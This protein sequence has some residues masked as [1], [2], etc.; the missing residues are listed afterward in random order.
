MKRQ[1]LHLGRNVKIFYVH[2][3]ITYKQS[4]LAYTLVGSLSSLD[5]FQICNDQERC[6]SKFR[7]ALNILH[8]SNRVDINECDGIHRDYTT[9]IQEAKYLSEYKEFRILED[10]V[11]RLFFNSLSGIEKYTK[12]CS[13]CYFCLLDRL[14][15][16]RD[17]LLTKKSLNQISWNMI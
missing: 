3:C 7:R 8:S 13:C 6:I 17:F 11:D 2:L 9:F 4:P 5:P 1:F 16:S 15:L 14:V 12:L 10:R